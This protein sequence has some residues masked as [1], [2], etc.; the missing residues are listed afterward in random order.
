[1]EMPF[2]FWYLDLHGTPSFVTSKRYRKTLQTSSAEDIIEEDIRDFTLKPFSPFKRQDS[3][4][5]EVE[6]KRKGRKFIMRRQ[7]SIM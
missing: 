1:M 4:Q 5:K 7:R 6:K 3:S 2:G